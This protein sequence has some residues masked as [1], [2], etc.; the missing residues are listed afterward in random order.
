MSLPIQE[1]RNKAMVA[2]S[3]CGFS[4]YQSAN[5]LGMERRNYSKTLK[6]WYNEHYQE[7]MD[8]IAKTKKLNLTKPKD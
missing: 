1:T 7:I 2:L 5:L 4:N 6:R 3:I 8:S